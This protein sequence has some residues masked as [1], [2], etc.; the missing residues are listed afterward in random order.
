MT[1]NSLTVGWLPSV[2]RRY[3]DIFIWKIMEKGEQIMW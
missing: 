2:E 1:G 3:L